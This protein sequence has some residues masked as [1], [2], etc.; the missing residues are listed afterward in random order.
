M[1]SSLDVQPIS[2]LEPAAPPGLIAINPPYGVRMGEGDGLR[3]LYAQLG[4]TMRR[5]RSGWGFAMLS[6]DPRLEQQTG[7]TLAERF[8]TSNGGIPVRLMVADIP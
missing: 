6:A 5:A 7:L 3:N 2:A 8:R 1:C 4:H